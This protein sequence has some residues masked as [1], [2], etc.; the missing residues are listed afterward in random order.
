VKEAAAA[1]VS[2]EEAHVA[3][4]SA[5]NTWG[6]R[7]NREAKTLAEGIG[8]VSAPW[9]PTN[10]TQKR[11]E[12]HGDKVVL[13]S[14]PPLKR[15]ICDMYQHCRIRR[16]RHGLLVSRQRVS[17]KR[18]TKNAQRTPTTFFVTV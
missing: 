16:D 4:T 14:S 7:A 6:C 18:R 12:V 13:G 15:C 2:R 10:A 8:L 11:I 17:L 1:R 9:L 3:Q 5:R